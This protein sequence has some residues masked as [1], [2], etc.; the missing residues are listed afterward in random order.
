MKKSSQRPN[1][2]KKKQQTMLFAISKATGEF[3]SIDHV[4]RGLACECVCYKCKK[5]VEARQ[6][7]IRSPH[8]AHC[9]NTECF[10][11]AEEG[12]YYQFFRLLNEFKMFS[13]PKVVWKSEIIKPDCRVKL[14][15][16][17]LNK[18]GPQYPPELICYCGERCFQILLDFEKY[19]DSKDLLEFEEYGKQND[20]AIIKINI[21]DFNKLKLSQIIEQYINSPCNKEWVFNP[22]LEMKTNEKHRTTSDF[23]S[24]N[25]IFSQA[26]VGYCQVCGKVKPEEEFPVLYLEKDGTFTGKCSECMK[27]RP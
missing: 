13:F 22:L 19:Y 7:E 26:K 18:D 20:R 6:G 14:T 2:K 3:V 24:E 25:N 12:S 16:V 11:S 9:N 4:D 8:F 27:S 17:K 21:D 10:F 15:E 1:I 5:P 23:E